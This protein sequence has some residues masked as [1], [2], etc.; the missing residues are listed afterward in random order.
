MPV[1]FLRNPTG[2]MPVRFLLSAD[3]YI[4]NL[5]CSTYMPFL[6]CIANLVRGGVGVGLLGPPS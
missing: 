1:E 6:A 3:K 5:Q 4:Y 2:E